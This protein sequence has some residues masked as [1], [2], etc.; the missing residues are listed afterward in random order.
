[1]NNTQT[2]HSPIDTTTAGPL[3]SL[4]PEAELQ[5]WADMLRAISDETAAGRTLTPGSD[6]AAIRAAQLSM[7]GLWLTS[8]QVIRVKALAGESVPTDPYEL[9]IGGDATTT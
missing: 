2:T 1:M 7:L 8:L 3:V 6:E 5:A 4:P 9:P